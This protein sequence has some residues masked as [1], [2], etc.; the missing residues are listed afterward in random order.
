MA[1]AKV[2]D[3]SALM[4]KIKLVL[5]SFPQWDVL[6]DTGRERGLSDFE[7]PQ[8]TFILGPAE[9]CQPSVVISQQE[10]SEEEDSH[11]SSSSSSSHS[12]QLSESV[13]PSVEAEPVRVLPESEVSAPETQE[14]AP[15]QN[16]PVP[17]ETSA[18]LETAPTA[19]PDSQAESNPSTESTLRSNQTSNPTASPPPPVPKLAPATSLH[20]RPM[21]V[22]SSNSPVREPVTKVPIMVTR[23]EDVNRLRE[24]LAKTRTSVPEHKERRACNGCTIT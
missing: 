5:N 13:P 17:A 20:S 12:Q 24:E 22:I 7:Q 19:L 1:E 16:E 15:P 2:P 11:S 4:G 8:T 21:M 23:S 10:A 18:S 9:E 14:S 6:P 3:L